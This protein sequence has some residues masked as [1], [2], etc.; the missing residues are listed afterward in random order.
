[1]DIENHVMDEADLEEII[2]DLVRRLSVKQRHELINYLKIVAEGEEKRDS[3]RKD[4]R[5]SV[6]YAIDDEVFTDTLE[7]IS[8]GGAFIR[9]SQPF[10]AGHSTSL[11][12]TLPGMDRA[13][14]VTGRIVRL[15][16]DGFGVRFSDENKDILK[17]VY[18][19]I[20]NSSE[21]DPL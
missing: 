18:A 16:E 15:T 11:V 7:N 9:T 17:S 19:S 21:K 20:V 13:V 3:D 8:P 5:I 4:I 6:D 12:F 1:M 2:L 10:H 14:K